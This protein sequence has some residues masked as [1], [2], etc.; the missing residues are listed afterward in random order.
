[1]SFGSHKSS[2]SIPRI[3]LTETAKDKKK[4]HTK[5]DPSVA[6]SEAQPGERRSHPLYTFTVVDDIETAA[7][8]LDKSTMESIRNLQHRDRHGNL[9]STLYRPCSP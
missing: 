8:A 7:Q 6:I 9:I 1:M 4:M 2:N 3:D 5:A